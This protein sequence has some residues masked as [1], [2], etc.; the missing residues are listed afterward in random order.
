MSKGG[1]QLNLDDNCFQVDGADEDPR[2]TALRMLNFEAQI[3]EVC[4]AIVR[5]H[6]VKKCE[7]GDASVIDQFER[8]FPRTADSVTN[9]HVIFAVLGIETNNPALYNK[10]HTIA[11][12]FCV[13]CDGDQMLV[14]SQ[15]VCQH[16]SR[17]CEDASF[18]QL[19]VKALKVP[20]WPISDA[21]LAKSAGLDYSKSRSLLEMM[22]E[23][24]LA[25]S[26]DAMC[27]TG[28]MTAATGE[29]QLQ[30]DL[31]RNE[32]VL[33]GVAVGISSSTPN[34]VVKALTDLDIAGAVELGRG[35]GGSVLK[36]VHKPTGTAFAVKQ[37]RLSADT[38][39]Q[40]QAELG[41]V[42][43]ES[44]NRASGLSPFVTQCYGV[45]CSDAT[46]YI[47]MELMSG[48][49]KD[50]LGTKAAPRSVPEPLLR[51]I[52]FQAL[53]GLSYMHT[54]RRQ[55]HRD[56][57]PHNILFRRSDGAVKLTDFGISSTQ[58]ET[59]NFNKKN[60][61]C[62]TIRYMSPLVVENSD[63]GYEADLWSF[64]ATLLELAIGTLPYNGDSPF[65][66]GMLQ[67]SPPRLPA[68]NPLTNVPFSPEFQTFI[69]ALLDVTGKTPTA[70]KL[71]LHPW[72]SGITLQ[73]STE[74]VEK[75]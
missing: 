49:L 50:L 71:L 64:G 45:F 1:F 10:N 53:K 30:F 52:A 27:G 16:V 38:I 7:G 69:A 48:S 8:V 3:Q 12:N 17:L 18:V 62:G 54:T 56:I 57:K 29:T 40:A 37:I 6:L 15:L 36:A 46:L 13:D 59:V 74:A 14:A 20:Q 41:V 19:L 25:S 39:K 58:M 70:E 55:L 28:T 75:L 31:L 61:Y 23:S 68:T 2:V 60:T 47:V 72:L 32:V 43:A 63:Y 24:A 9:K 44:E 33:N 51:A 67:H 21:A 5:Q 11:E 34:A 65:A 4:T 35:A 26:G 66:I 73:S 42:W 22:V